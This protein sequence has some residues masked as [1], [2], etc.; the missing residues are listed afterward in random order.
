MKVNGQHWSAD[1]KSRL[2]AALRKP[3]A[4]PAH[5]ADQFGL[6]RASVQ[7]L[8]RTLKAEPMS[9]PSRPYIAPHLPDADNLDELLARRR[10]EAARNIAAGAARQLIPIKITTPGPIG[11]AL[12]G[13]PHIDD[14]GCDFPMLERHL[15]LCEP[16]GSYLFASCVGDFSN[17]W[18]GRL[19]RLYANQST[20]VRQSWMLVEWFARKL[21]WLFMIRGNHDCWA[22]GNDPL[23]WILRDVTGVDEKH[24]VRLALNH[25]GG[26]T[27]RLHARHDFKGHSQFNGLHGLV[28]ETLFGDRDHIIAA[29]HRH[30]G[31]DAGEVM[32]D[33]VCAQ[34]VRVSGYKVVD[35]YALQGGFK[36]KPIHP[37]AL[38]V[39]DP[40]RPETSRD[41]AWCAPTFEEGVEYLDWKRARFDGTARVVV[42][43][44]GR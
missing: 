37:A 5:V 13:D 24:A 38:I 41:R 28:K 21:N 7:R 23:D 1:L 40:A 29:G 31:A 35:D 12:F 18:T 9:E 44:A 25:P 36:R 39:I 4:V 6:R 8:A 20:T 19:S 2:T 11:L 3:G 34:L 16:R 15:D 43:A 42:K 17:N 32:P 22:G 30:F 27:T 14:P 33:G 10:T 26:E